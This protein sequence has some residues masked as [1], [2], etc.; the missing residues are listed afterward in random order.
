MKTWTRSSVDQLCAGASH[1]TGSYRIRVGEPMLVY[2][3]PRASGGTFSLRGRCAQCADEPVPEDLPPYVAPDNTIQPSVM[4]HG[5]A[6][7][8]L[9]WKRRR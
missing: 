2:S 6:T 1:G 7:L 8:P 3:F 9:E 4:V 5:H